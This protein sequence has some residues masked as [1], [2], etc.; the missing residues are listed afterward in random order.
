MHAAGNVVEL[1]SMNF[2]FPPSRP[3]GKLVFN[4]RS[5]GRCFAKSNRCLIPTSA[6]FEFTGKRYPKSKH[7]FTLRDAPFMAIAG[8][9]RETKADGPPAFAMLTTDPGP[10]IEPY[11][12]SRGA[13]AVR[14]GALDLSDTPRVRAAAPAASLLAWCRDGA[15]RPR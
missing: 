10:D 9:W 2:S 4:F 6:F 1:Y 14:L 11:R 15:D 5:E 13:A 8:I 12:P 3:G 7:R